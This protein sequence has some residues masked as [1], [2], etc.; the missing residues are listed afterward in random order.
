MKPRPQ[1]LVYNKWGIGETNWV[2]MAG[3]I[4]VVTTKHI[5]LKCVET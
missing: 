4:Y 2:P 5:R 1:T 3:T